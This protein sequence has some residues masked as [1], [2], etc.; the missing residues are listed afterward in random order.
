[1]LT[2]TD[3]YIR[4]NEIKNW[5]YCPRI[6]FYI[7]C[8]G[9]DRETAL[10][11]AGLQ[12]EQDTK[13]R[14]RR[15]KHALHAVHHGDRHFDVDLVHHSLELVGQ[16]DE[17]V[18]TQQGVYLVDYKDTNQDY[19]YWRVQM[20]AYRLCVEAS[21]QIVLG[22]YIYSIPDQIYHPMNLTKTHHKKLTATLNSIRTILAKPICPPPTAHYKKCY[23]CQYA[24][25][26]NDVI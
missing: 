11:K 1:M 23:T 22:S 3:H 18:I 2:D 16:L 19:G 7:L 14:M 20:L 12:A 4:I 21:G 24:R 17:L 25:W 8:M 5:L 15:R 13:K 9:L 6:T 26:C 10:S